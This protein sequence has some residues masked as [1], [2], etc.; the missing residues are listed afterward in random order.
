[1]AKSAIYAV[2]TTA[3]TAVAVGEV[4]PFTTI[5]RRFGCAVNLDNNGI[6]IREAGYYDVDV[7]ATVTATA[8]GN[9]SAYLA[10]DGVE[11]A[12]TRVTVTAQVIGDEVILPISGLIRV[13]P[14]NTDTLTIVIEDNAITT[15]R[16]S[17]EVVKL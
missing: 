12:G 1:M 11:V 17:I 9:V 15:V 13:L 7:I 6:L 3:G 8:V 4:L 2:N 16:N 5:N 14:Y 10:Q